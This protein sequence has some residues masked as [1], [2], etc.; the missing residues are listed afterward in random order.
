MDEGEVDDFWCEEDGGT[1]WNGCGETNNELNREWLAREASFWKVGY[2]EGLDVGKRKTIQEGFNKGF[3]CG[4]NTGFAWGQARGALSTLQAFGGQLPG[5]SAKLEDISLLGIRLG[6]ATQDAAAEAFLK[7]QI[8]NKLAPYHE[9]KTTVDNIWAEDAMHETTQPY[10]TNTP[11]DVDGI[12]A[13]DNWPV[14]SREVQ[15]ASVLSCSIGITL[16]PWEQAS[17]LNL[18]DVSHPNLDDVQQ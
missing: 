4:A 14:I 8:H 11:G 9:Q 3:S 6:Q 7:H 10:Q 2:R 5:T 15:S 12:D 16:V 1:H 17:S 13:A 18:S